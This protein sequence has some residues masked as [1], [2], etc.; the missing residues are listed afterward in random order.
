[1]TL[2]SRTYV[3]LLAIVFMALGGCQEDGS[4]SQQT[5]AGTVEQENE[6]EANPAGV[7]SRVDHPAAKRA[8]RF[9]DA[10]KYGDFRTAA[11][12][13][14]ESTSEGF[15][16]RND[17][18]REV[19]ETARK[20]RSEEACS[21]VETVSGPALEHVEDPARLLVQILAVVCDDP[22]AD[23]IDYGRRV[24]LG[25]RKGWMEWTKQ[26]DSYRIVRVIEG[27]R[28][29]I[30]Y[31]DLQHAET[32]GPDHRTLRMVEVDGAWY[33]AARLLRRVRPDR[34]SESRPNRR[35]VQK[36]NEPSAQ[37]DFD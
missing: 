32:V 33:V 15:Y 6:S 20:K 37:P 3:S 24:L 36:Q 14:L 10:L 19:L 26:I 30:V 2:A 21:E 29:T 28:G 16:C 23:C 4:S 17:T 12:L 13:H 35:P 7:R 9:L 5:G 34:P 22:E 25:N 18:F 31:V 1:M 27:K 8:A 11:S